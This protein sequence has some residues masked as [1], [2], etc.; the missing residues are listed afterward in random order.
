MSK[1]FNIE[2]AYMLISLITIT[3]L[4]FMCKNFPKDKLAKV[5]VK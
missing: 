3:P 4:V 2:L 5:E 1:L